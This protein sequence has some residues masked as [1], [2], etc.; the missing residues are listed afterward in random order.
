MTFFSIRRK[1]AE[2]Q[3][4][5][6]KL[7]VIEALIFVLPLL[8]LF[9]ILYRG[10]YHFDTSQ[11]IL[12]AVLAIFALAG[13][14]ILRQILDRFYGIAVSL[15]KAESGQS[16]TMDDKTDV[17]ELREISASVSSLLV[18]LDRTTEELAQKAF[19]IATIKESAE[20]AK[21]NLDMDEQMQLLL[22]KS[23]AVTGAGIGSV[24]MVEPEA[25]QKN[26][27]VSKT[28]PI[29]LSTLY[30]FRVAAAIGHGEA[31]PK[32]S[33]LNID[34]SVAKAV[35][36]ERG[37]LLVRDIEQDPRTL[38]ANDP[39]YGAPSFLS[40]PIFVGDTVAAI[41]NLAGKKKDGPFDS[42][43]ERVLSI[44]FREISIALENALL[45]SRIMEQLARIRQHNSELEKESEG[46]LRTE[47]ALVESENKFR[48]LVEKSNDIIYSIGLGG[49]FTYVNPAAE[50]IVGFS[51]AE[52]LGKTYRSLIRPDFREQTEA[53]YKKQLAENLSSTYAEF[54]IVVQD[55]SLRW[56]GQH[57]QLL[58]KE[59]QPVGFQAVARDITE[60]KRAEEAL[61]ES[62]HRYRTLVGNIPDIIVSIDHRG[63]ITAMNSTVA[64][65]GYSEEELI[66]SPFSGLIHP[67]DR[68]PV[69]RD[70][71]EAIVRRRNVT[72]GL[73]FRILG[74]DGTVYWE[75]LTSHKLWDEKGGYLQDDGV[76]R[77]ITDRKKEEEKIAALNANLS[78]ANQKLEAAYAL[79]R[80]HRDKLIEA[81]ARD[82]TGFLVDKDGF[83]Q[84]TTENGPETM[85]K[86]RDQ[87]LG[88]RIMDLLRDPYQ[89]A[90]AAELN[91]AWL[92]I[93]Q[94]IDAE[95][96]SAREEMK[97]VKIRMTRLALADFRLLLVTMQ[98]SRTDRGEEP[99]MRV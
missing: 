27:P 32:G 44:M 46:R 57:V 29:N 49:Q 30:R 95:T 18:R 69:A 33:Y 87:L 98:E 56:I 83:I 76:M 80:E 26:V 55:G 38:K 12:F 90:F 97:R 22:E 60:S 88:A 7:V 8:I 64:R 37:P 40:M 79:M 72:R 24:L 23:M 48:L 91:R 16:V 94:G 75:E 5:R 85:G 50:R 62:E 25:R 17:L 51:A 28:T 73:E 77:D 41:V 65:Y 89:E 31:L 3:S 68:E 35:L 2:P 71:Q 81:Q 21:S 45:Q 6:D 10:H 1:G 36:L 58:T 70:F 63:K 93:D 15:K 19:E 54:P 39:K 96:V 84:G 4:V 66:G 53:F 61:K 82:V 43:D 13:M 78:E 47:R 99:E 9:Y 14:V 92:G 59:E 86:R 20:I 42:N 67:E 52:L 34:S 74:K 11:V